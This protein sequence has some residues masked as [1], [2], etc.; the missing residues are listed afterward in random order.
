MKK[1]YEIDRLDRCK[2]F[3]SEEYRLRVL[4]WAD[5]RNIITKGTALIGGLITALRLL[6]AIISAI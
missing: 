3:E 6:N 1:Q 2:L 4:I 5:I